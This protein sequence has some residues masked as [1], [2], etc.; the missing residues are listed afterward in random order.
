MPALKLPPV[1]ALGAISYG[2]PATLAVASAPA[3]A[4]LTRP[5]VS[6][7]FSPVLLNSVP[8]KLTV[9]PYVLLPSLATI[10]KGAGVTPSLP[11]T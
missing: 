1:A 10:P 9:L 7:F 6:P 8:L 4:R 2:L 11:L 3:L 5:I